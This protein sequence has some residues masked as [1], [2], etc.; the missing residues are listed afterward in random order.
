[1]ALVKRSSVYIASTE[2]IADSRIL[3]WDRKTI[4]D[5]AAQHTELLDNALLIASDYMN[6]AIATQ[7]SL[8]SHT[9]RQR[10]A[11]VLL[12]L[13]SGIGHEI[14]GGIELKV[15][16]EELASAANITTFTASRIMSEWERARMVRKSRGKVLIPSP[17]RLL[18]EDVG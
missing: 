16:N 10:L 12:N 7:V 18:L 9:A 8:T 5:I 1:M 15:R 6:L 4:R 13:A 11:L 2:A 14:S 3:V 17:E